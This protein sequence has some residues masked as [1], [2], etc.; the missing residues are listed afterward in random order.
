MRSSS[1]SGGEEENSRDAGE[2][3][4]PLRRAHRILVGGGVAHGDLR[5]AE[6]AIGPRDQ[7]RGHDQEFGDQGQLGEIQRHAEHVHH[8]DADAQRLDLRDDDGGEISPGDGA[9]A[10]DHHHHEGV[11]Q[12]RQV[13]R[14][15]GRLAGQ[16]QRAAEAGE[17][18]AAGE[19]EREEQGLVDA[20]RADHLAVL[21]G[22]ADQPAEAR[23]G[24]NEVQADQH[25]RPGD[26]QEQVVA[27]EAA[28]ENFDRAAQARRARSEQIFVAP[29]PERRIVDDQQHREG[30]E[31]LEQLRRLVDAPKQQDLDQRADRRDQQRG[32]HDGAPEAKS[33]AHLGRDA[34]GNVDAQHVERAVGD[35][36]DARDAEDQRQAGA[37][38]EQA[39]GG[40]KPVECLEQESVERHQR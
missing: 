16:L 35:V 2:D 30:G 27:R 18:R 10:A 3:E 25:D 9:H 37:D 12:H 17:R 40:R 22:G 5:P 15:V 26:D 11:A 31:Q 19:H 6:Q 14:E 4:R 28:I 1:G 32:E 24:Q 33:A 23:L 7:H 13:H 8:A 20:E 39:G 34:V 21:R 38:E 36:D 29:D